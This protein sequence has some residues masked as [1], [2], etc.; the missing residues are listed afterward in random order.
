MPRSESQPTGPSMRHAVSR[1]SLLKAAG[2]GAGAF[3]I[4]HATGD[5]GPLRRAAAAGTLPAAPR[6]GRVIAE[7]ELLNDD[8]FDP[9][10]VIAPGGWF[11]SVYGAGDQ[12]GSLNEVTPR[13]T[14][15]ALQ[16]IKN[17]PQ[18][19]PRTYNLGEL[20]EEG[21]PAFGTRQYVQVRVGGDPA[22]IPFG[23]NQIVGMEETI[24]TTYQIATQV[25]GLPHIGVKHHYYNGLTTEEMTA[26]NPSG[27]NFLG[28]EHVN[29]FITRGVLLDVLAVKVAQGASAA[30]GD[31][32]DGKPIL[33][34]S[35]RITLEDLEAAM[36][37]GTI[38]AIEPGDVVMIRT[39]WT[40]LFDG[41]DPVKK[42]RYLATEP[43]IYLREARWLAH[44]R[45]AIVASD[46]WALEVLPAPEPWTAT[47]FFPVHQ[48]LITHHGIRIG[49][50]F[51]AE[52]LSADK[53][54]EFVF[55]NAPQRAKGA[56]ASNNAPGA[57]GQRL[58][59][60][61]LG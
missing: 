20:M 1:R 17:N 56:T 30:L 9:D 38:K 33:A 51:R 16:L 54:Y 40:H 13:K 29:P 32:V 22:S 23:D 3:F 49:E 61:P 11:P 59:G 14:L 43:G 12:L 36:A 18:R 55:F 60:P 44:F 34:N 15:A 58:T 39:G 45:P 8:P 50:A 21:M 5:Y 10:A 57:L 48:E 35:Y 27:V 24:D 52:E 2:A 46:T 26:G 28:Q 37:H 4:A 47:Q 42:A 41:S 6:G 25:D 19:P 31:P 7:H 53:I